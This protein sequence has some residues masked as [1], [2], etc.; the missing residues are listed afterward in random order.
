MG[1]TYSATIPIITEIFYIPGTAHSC[2]RV[3]PCTQ[4]TL[5][6]LMMGKIY[7]KENPLTNAI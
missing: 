2:I 1:N 7:A 6:T 5:Y 3:S 4:E